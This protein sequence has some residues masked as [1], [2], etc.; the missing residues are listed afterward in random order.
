MLTM[1]EVLD[2]PQMYEEA[3]FKFLATE[4]HLGSTNLDFQWATSHRGISC[5]LLAS[6]CAT[7][8]TLAGPPM[9]IPRTQCHACAESPLG[10]PGTRCHTCAELPCCLPRAYRVS[11]LFAAWLC[12]LVSTSTEMEQEEL[13][14]GAGDREKLKG[15]GPVLAPE[16][17]APLCEASDGSAGVQVP[18]TEGCCTLP[19]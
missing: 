16:F 18:L 11:S 19:L 14:R 17:T 9:G 3:V 5:K 8:T 2:A 7:R 15:E 6:H 1:S 12:P 13:K 4:T 10:I